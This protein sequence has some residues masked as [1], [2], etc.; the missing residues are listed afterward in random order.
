MPETSSW[1]MKNASV[2]A[3]GVRSSINF[4]AWPFAVVCSCGKKS[5]SW[6]RDNGRDDARDGE[7]N[8][9]GESIN[10]ALKSKG[11]STACSH[12]C[13]PKPRCRKSRM[14]IF[15]AFS[16]SQASIQRKTDSRLTM[17]VCFLIPFHHLQCHL[18]TNC[19][20]LLEFRCFRRRK[21]KK[22]TRNRRCCWLRTWRSFLLVNSPV[23]TRSSQSSSVLQLITGEGKKE[24]YWRRYEKQR[25][26]S[27]EELR[28]LLW[29][30]CRL[31]IY[32]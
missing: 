25:G 5:D 27:R 32:S 20:V 24:G 7:R 22:L 29:Y 13:M 14:F 21:E 2:T 4:V 19:T 15:P 6:S 11:S 26:K 18:Q 31:K 9:S 28:R 16:Q 3:P 23:Y 1:P 17:F 10:H 8:G 12:T 30:N